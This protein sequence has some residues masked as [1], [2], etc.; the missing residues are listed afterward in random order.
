MATIKDI[1]KM[2]G[3]STATVS[4]IINGK[5]EAKPETIERVLKL[6]E[7]LNYQPNKMAQSLKRRATNLIAVMVPNL[8]NPFFGEL[9]TAI[10]TEAEKFGLQ[11]FLCDTNDSREKVEYF[12]DTI[13]DNYCLGAI[14]CT[15]QVTINDLE[16]LEKRGVRTI[17]IDR[18]YFHHPYSAINIDQLNGAYMA[19]HHLI[20]RGAE[21]IV[22]LSGPQEDAL[23]VEREKG[24][25][26]ALTSHN[27]SFS[28]VLNGDYTLQ[29]GYEIIDD[30]FHQKQHFD[31]IFASNDLMAIGALRACKDNNKAVPKKIKIIGNDDLT[32]DNFIEPRLTTMS[33]E[34]EKVSAAII[35]ELFNI[36][37]KEKQPQKLVFPPRLVLRETT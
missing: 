37:Q 36:K 22:F 27:L 11:V 4:R 17:T 25:L 10:E 33:Q 32:L 30:L 34:K 28:Q 16:T 5:G 18:S 26:M 2:A 19:T 20:E 23:S 6:V 12:L 13:A 1:A 21:K 24:Y 31:G 15:L 9:V 3:V 35:K 14:I 29:K 7:E 8:K